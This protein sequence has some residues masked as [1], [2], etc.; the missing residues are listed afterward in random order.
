M[1]IHIVFASSNRSLAVYG[2]GERRII[3]TTAQMVREPIFPNFLNRDYLFKDA[4]Q[5]LGVCHFQGWNNSQNVTTT[6]TNDMVH[7]T[8][9][10]GLVRQ[11]QG[12]IL[13]ID[14]NV[15]TWRGL[16]DLLAYHRVAFLRII[17]LEVMKPNHIFSTS[18]N[19]F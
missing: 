10:A 18:V 2:D 17:N 16:I 9:A 8:Y 14:G 19:S 13:L 15:Q 7:L 1:S 3:H 12:G 6:N 4:D 5:S 11:P